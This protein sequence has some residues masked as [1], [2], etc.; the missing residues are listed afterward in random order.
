MRVIKSGIVGGLSRTDSN[1]P[2]RTEKAEQE[3]WEWNNRRKELRGWN[4]RAKAAGIDPLP[5][6]RPKNSV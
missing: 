4:L 5:P 1:K 6:Q 3:T 2:Q